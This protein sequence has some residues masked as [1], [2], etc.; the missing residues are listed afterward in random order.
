MASNIL[1]YGWRLRYRI[2]TVL[3]ICSLVKQLRW[4]ILEDHPQPEPAE[5]SERQSLHFIEVESLSPKWRDTYEI[6]EV[7]AIELT[8]VLYS[9]GR[10]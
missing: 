1:S 4:K 3:V 7:P 6:H 5:T 9:V 10:R 2:D 8:N